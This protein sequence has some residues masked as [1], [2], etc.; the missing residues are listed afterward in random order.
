MRNNH[1]ELLSGLPENHKP[2]AFS[3]ANNFAEAG[4]SDPLG[5]GPCTHVSDSGINGL[6]FPK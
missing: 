5:G 6:Q 4:L 3:I 2:F 1:A